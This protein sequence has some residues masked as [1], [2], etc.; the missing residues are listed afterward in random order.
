MTAGW[1][2]HAM[3]ADGWNKDE[4]AVKRTWLAV[5][6]SFPTQSSITY[7][8]E[9]KTQLGLH[10][11][12]AFLHARKSINTSVFYFINKIPL[13]THTTSFKVRDALHLFMWLYRNLYC[14]CIN[15]IKPIWCAYTYVWKTRNLKTAFK[16]FARRSSI[17]SV[18][19][20]SFPCDNSCVHQLS[21]SLDR[22]TV[23]FSTLVSLLL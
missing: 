11:S 5:L 4:S 14:T 9:V 13:E 7:L 10:S 17:F 3:H 18:Y 8:F 21:P 19:S 15:C 22:K 20:L 12:H 23:Q 1:N 2:S 16:T 6:D